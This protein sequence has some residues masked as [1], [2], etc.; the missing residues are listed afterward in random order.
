MRAYEG[1]SQLSH[2]ETIPLECVKCGYSDAVE[3]ENI[4]HSDWKVLEVKGEGEGYYGLC[5]SCLRTWQF[6]TGNFPIIH[7]KLVNGQW[8]AE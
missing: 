1:T 4:N 8:V 7:M 5:P 2:K 6:M 3:F